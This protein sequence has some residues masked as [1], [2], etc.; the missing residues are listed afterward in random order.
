MLSVG[1]GEG[2]GDG[3]GL[4]RRPRPRPGGAEG[5]LGS[6]V[7]SGIGVKA[8]YGASVESVYGAGVIKRTPSAC[9]AS[10]VAVVRAASIVPRGST[11]SCPALGCGFALFGRTMSFGF[12]ATSGGV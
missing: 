9:V 3:V 2:D 7:A 4:P 6:S 5:R 12:A 8:E 10:S 1:E 11:R